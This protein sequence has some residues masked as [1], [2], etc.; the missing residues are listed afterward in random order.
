MKTL[1][2]EAGLT[3]SRK[4]IILWMRNA[5]GFEENEEDL[6]LEISSY[7]KSN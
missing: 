7:Y 3:P 1:Q 5:Q 2:V 4:Q 6:T